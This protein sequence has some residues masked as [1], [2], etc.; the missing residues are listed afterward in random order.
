M[1][2]IIKDVGLGLGLSHIEDTSFFGASD[3][4]TTFMERVQSRGGK[5][6][7]YQVLTPI[8]ADHHHLRFDFDERA[9][10]VALSICGEMILRLS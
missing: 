2:D 4:A 5:A 7:Y 6:L 8:A 9:L 10:G 1:A 3:D